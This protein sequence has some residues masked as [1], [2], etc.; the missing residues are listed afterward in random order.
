M[1]LQDFVDGRS[2]YS[3]N[4]NNSDNLYLSGTIV[5]NSKSLEFNG[6]YTEIIPFDYHVYTFIDFVKVIKAEGR[7][8]SVAN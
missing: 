6:N 1:S 7:S 5:N 3:C 4:L 8:V 2:T